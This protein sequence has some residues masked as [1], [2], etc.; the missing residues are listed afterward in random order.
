MKAM[1]VGQ[2]L[3]VAFMSWRRP[4]YE[5]TLVFPNVIKNNKFLRFILKFQADV[6]DTKLGPE[7]TTRYF[8][9]W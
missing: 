8:K 2:M 9:C 1:R 3:S 5:D 7:I 6:R 4:S